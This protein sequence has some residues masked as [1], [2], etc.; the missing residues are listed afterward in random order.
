M[1]IT[2]NRAASAA[3]AA[4]LALAALLVAP[5]AAQAQE[6]QKIAIV[7]TTRA[8][9]TSKDGRAAEQKLKD[10]R[11]RKREEFTPLQAELRRLQDELETQRFVLS[12]EA[13]QD[14]QLE[15]V[16]K[17]RSLE[18]N[19]EEA[20]EDFEIEQRKLMQPILKSIMS[21][22]NQMARDKGY[23]VV[24]E[25]SSPGVLY[26]SEQLDITDRLIEL[27]NEKS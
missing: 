23:D 24:I 6:A 27:L 21:V 1:Q 11:D 10:L 18:R 25:R 14:R 19:L 15:I 3:C 26:Y 5:A 4:A 22:V 13:L 12:K 8:A 7:D 16:K 9:A 2:V 17:Q 20:Q